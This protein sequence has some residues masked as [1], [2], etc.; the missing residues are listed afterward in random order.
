ME[1]LHLS[2]RAF[3]RIL[4]MARTCADL[5]GVEDI[6]ITHLAE[7]TNYRTLDQKKLGQDLKKNHLTKTILSRK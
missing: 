1:K 7:A 3:D 5:E 6:E 2:A 4:K